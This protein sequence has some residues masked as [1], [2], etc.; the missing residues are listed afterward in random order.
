MPD[1]S[2]LSDDP[3]LATVN[4]ESIKLAFIAML[5]HLPPRQR[6]VL[7][8]REVLCWKAEEV[9]ALLETTVASVNS[10]LQRARATLGSDHIDLNDPTPPADERDRAL[11]ASYLDAFE[12]YDMDSMR[13]LLRDDAILSMPP[14]EM[15]MRGPAEIARWMLGPGAECRGS[16]LVPVAANGT[17]GFGQYR[18]QPDGSFAPWSLQVIELRDGKISGIN[19]FLDTATLFPLFGLPDRL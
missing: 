16:R 9:A 5:Q 8:M 7:I 4:R 14:Y 18:V 12:R 17:G 3:E 2:V 6:A 10:A 11:L 13:E 19:A 15:W 1:A